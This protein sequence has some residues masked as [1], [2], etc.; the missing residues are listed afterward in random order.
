MTAKSTKPIVA[1]TVPLISRR[2][3]KNDY[4]HL[5]FGPFPRTRSI[6]PGQFLHLDLPNC[7]VFYRRA[8][9]VGG[10]NQEE[11]SV[12]IILKVVG[13]GS[14]AL[15]QMRPGDEVN[16]LGP[17][18]NPF[19]A[20]RKSQ[21]AI[22]VAGGVGFPPLLYFAVH[23]IQRGFD[24]KRI[25]FLYG[26]RS[27]P[28]IVDR[29]RIKKLGVKFIPTTED[30]SFGEKGLITTPL[31]RALSSGDLINPVVYSCGPEPMLKAVDQIA[32]EFETP[33]ELALEAAMPCGFGICLGCIVPLKAGGNARVCHEGPVFP[34]GAV[35][36]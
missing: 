35:A 18:G 15:A 30:G 27:S 20:P 21:T 36:L 23:L 9:S 12:E 32:L 26:G 22:M 2:D 11:K 33:G 5:V 10:V 3:L 8:F 16:I 13:R 7:P 4:M 28:D 14:R 29:A 6:R 17:L 19:T 1:R 25:L 24:P 34:V 31:V